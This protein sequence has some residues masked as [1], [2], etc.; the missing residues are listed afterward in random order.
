MIEINLLPG[1]I[2]KNPVKIELNK[3]LYFN[4]GL[5]IISVLVFVHI[6]I[7]G[8]FIFRKARL[9]NLNAILPKIDS[10]LKE[11]NNIK[12]EF[13]V[14]QA[15]TSKILEITKDRLEISLVLNLLSINLPKGVWLKYL[16]LNESE[17]DLEGSVVSLKGDE[18][19]ILNKYLTG[20]KNEKNIVIFDKLELADVKKKTFQGIDLIDFVFKT[21]IK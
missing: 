4:I 6:L 19:A 13:K 8:V 12:S 11:I 16:K 10:D 14:L 18:V 17:F 1:G 9:N 2:K 5:I 15:D 21:K 3:E 20:L 7:G